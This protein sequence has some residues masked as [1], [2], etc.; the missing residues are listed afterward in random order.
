MS[1]P[2]A[3]HPAAAN[4][5]ADITPDAAETETIRIPRPRKRRFPRVLLIILLAGIFVC[6]LAAMIGAAGFAGVQAGRQ[7]ALIRQTSTVAAYVFDRLQKGNQL[8]K[9]RNFV[10]AQANFE[11][12]LK[13]EPDNTGVR[14]LAATAIALQTP[15]AVP[16]PTPATTPT[17]VVVD[18]GKLL[19]LAQAASTQ[20]HWDAVINLTS[21]LIDLDP[22]YEKGTIDDLRYTALVTRGLKRVR[23]DAIE[24]G[25]Y[26][27][28]QAATIKPLDSAAQGEKRVAGAYQNALNYVGADWEQAIALLQAVYRLAPRYRDVAQRL[29]TAYRDAGNDYAAALDWCPAAKMYARGVQFSSTSQL[30][31]KQKDADLKCLTATPVGATGISGTASLGNGL[32]V[33]TTI[34]NTAGVTGRLQFSRF[35]PAT[36]QYRY[37]VY[38]SASATAYDTGGGPQPAP[39]ASTGPDGTRI[40]Y[41]VLQ[42]GAWKVIVANS[43]GSSPQTIGDGT[44]PVWGPAGLIAYQTCS[45]QCGIHLINPDQP[46]SARRLTTSPSDI[47]M[48]WS[49]SGDKLVYTSNAGGSWEIYTV[50]TAGGF[51]KLTGFGVICGAPTFS[52]DGAR[53]AFISNRDGNWAVWVMN[54]DGNNASKFI[55]LGSQFPDWQGEKLVWSP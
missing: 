34:F 23:G 18:K 5:A 27:L 4:A 7:E 55:D 41:Q 29:A 30:E 12:I 51:Q 53:V 54:A 40:T 48:R 2:S 16:S 3:A 14:Q 28:D 31:A 46:G 8:L 32:G 47:D 42:D 13:Y 49:P 9:D 17:P 37:F 38:D 36:N 43:D 26:D 15:T 39:H 24:Q 21:E 6:S 10:L 1:D 22:G 11:E 19:G 45:D 25:I 20:E 33:S 35:D 50:T 44:Y 52:P